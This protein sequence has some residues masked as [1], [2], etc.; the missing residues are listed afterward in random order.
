[1]LFNDFESLFNDL[2]GDTNNKFKKI[3]E[4]LFNFDKP[5]DKFNFESEKPTKVERF[6]ED[7]YTF[8]K[9]TWETEYGSMVKIEMVN[10]PTKSRELPLESQLAK[11][12]KEERYEDAAKIRDEIKKIKTLSTEK[13]VAEQNN[14]WN[15]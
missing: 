12:I 15:F 6:E 3:V 4:Q 1:M 7:G 2:N 5:I 10:A 14:E 13:Q 11:A 9:Q 8:E